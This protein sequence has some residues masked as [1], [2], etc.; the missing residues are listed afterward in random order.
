MIARH[1]E[2]GEHHQKCSSGSV[3]H[4]EKQ[5]VSSWNYNSD[6][7]PRYRKQMHFIV[8]QILMK[9]LNLKMSAGFYFDQEY[10][11]IPGSKGF[12]LNF[13]F[14]SSLNRKDQI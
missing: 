7:R 9:C 10:F 11:I 14:P 5:S 8:T 13:L 3:A 4:R 2:E 12:F 6:E 1:E